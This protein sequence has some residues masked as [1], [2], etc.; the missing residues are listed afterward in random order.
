M[1]DSQNAVEA[2]VIPTAMSRP[3]E[4]D[5]A[6]RAA[7]EHIDRQAVRTVADGRPE[8]TRTGYAQDW[9]SWGKFC[10]ASVCPRSPFPP[11]RW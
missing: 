9:A 3:E 8:R 10:A 4:Y 7:L 5:A 2:V 11:A 6:T 1:S